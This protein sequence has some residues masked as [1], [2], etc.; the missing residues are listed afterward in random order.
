MVS[1]RMMQVIVDQVV[2]MVAVWHGGVP[3]ARAV[4]MTLDVAAAIV[5]R[6]AFG[7]VRGRNGHL[8]LDNAFRGDVVQVAIVQVIDV[9]I[10]LES[11]VTAAGTV[12]MLVVFV[13]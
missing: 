9:A 6:S 3:A 2:D 8:V 11:G 5:P 10:V 7:R 4:P 13:N 12:L 1:M